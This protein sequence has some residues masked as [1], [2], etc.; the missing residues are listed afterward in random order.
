MFKEITLP[1]KILGS[2]ADEKIDIFCYEIVD[3]TNK[4]ARL[5]ATDTELDASRAILFVADG[6]TEGRGRLGRSFY[7]PRST[8]L[9]M[10][11]LLVAPEDELFTRMTALCAVAV[12]KAVW[13]MM[14]VETGIKWVNDL[15]LGER[16]VAGILAESFVA[17]E[18]R[19]VALGIGIN[20][21]TE[22]FPE[23]LSAIAGSLTKKRRESEEEQRA[24]RLA[25][26]FS[27]CKE[28]KK[29]LQCRNVGEYMDIYRA[30]SCVI[31]REISFFENGREK[32]GRAADIND[33][34]ELVVDTADGRITLCGGE[35]SVRLR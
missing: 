24:D 32:R 10:T 31:G 28:M 6:Q 27:V 19:C 17:G 33:R 29:A 25:L 35:I 22:D 14:G 18:R 1:K 16:K 8:G 9:Y 23:E 15:Y 7:S 21:C 26:A 11:L 12:R 34:G 5:Y 2:F 3:S 20:I 13:D 30:A 4:R